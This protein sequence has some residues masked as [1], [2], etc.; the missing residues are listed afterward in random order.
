MAS[1]GEDQGGPVR[2]SGLVARG[3]GQGTV[4]GLCA[5]CYKVRNS[6]NSIPPE[7]CFSILNDTFDDD[8]TRSSADYIE[9]SLQSQYNARGRA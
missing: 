7:R 9:Y 1:S 6:P 2:P 8:Q 5:K 3:G 4:L